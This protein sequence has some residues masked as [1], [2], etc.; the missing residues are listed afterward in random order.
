MADESLAA[1]MDLTG[2]GYEDAFHCLAS[3]GGHLGEAVNR[4]FSIDAGPSRSSRSPPPPPPPQVI[5]DT[6]DD[7]DD[8]ERAPPLPVAR[9]NR[10]GAGG[11]PGRSSPFGSSPRVS[12][13][14]DSEM[15]TRGGSSRS[16]RRRRGRRD[17]EV[18]AKLNRGEQNHRAREDAPSRG[19]REEGGKRNRS[20]RRR[21]SRVVDIFADI[22]SDDEEEVEAKNSRRR[23]RL[24]P[25]DGASDGAEVEGSNR[26]RRFRENIFS[27]DE[28]EVEV[29][30]RSRRRRFRQSIFSDDEE[31]E[32]NNSSRRPN[33]GN[34]DVASD[35]GE[36]EEDAR[37]HVNISPDDDMEVDE[38]PPSP[39]PPPSKTIE[40]LFRVPRELTY[41]G[42][43]HDAKVHAARR[44]RWLLVNVQS[45]DL[46][47]VAQNRDVWGSDLM[48]QCV[49]EHFVLWQVDADAKL[50]GEG[51]EAKKVLCYYKLPQERLP[52]VVVV[53]PVTGQA[54]DKLYGND[55]NDFLVSVGPYTEHRP[56]LP[57]LAKKSS[58]SAGVQNNKKPATAAPAPTSRQEQAPTVRKP[59]E[60]AVAAMAVVPTG[61]TRHEQAPAVRK[62]VE[63]VAAAAAVAPTGQQPASSVEKVCKLRVRLPDGRVVAKE[64]GSQCAVTELF[65]YCRTELAAGAAAGKPFRLLRFLGSAREEIGIENASF[66]SLRLHMSTVSV[67]L[68]FS[69]RTL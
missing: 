21:R 11:A 62:P 39:P 60:T 5:S 2:C 19:G 66:E 58:A 34:N 7:P 31:E 4:F 68:G 6:D 27:D 40:D 30:H 45:L 44:T 23:R 24:N 65:A 3:C 59:A 10:R 52:V 50:G 48:A 49:R 28:E 53:D 57:F 35:G 36:K 12:R 47:S 13:W 9:P 1:F 54:M 8:A 26:R 67:E 29:N 61:Q 38:E 41:K 20:H 55:P 25:K 64:F 32:V 37:F 46:A 56:T 22:S 18:E 17:R 63:P 33:P 14:D 42:G 16:S 43:F 69:S 51:E 15:R